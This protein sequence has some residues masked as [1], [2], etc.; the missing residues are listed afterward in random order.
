MSRNDYNIN[1]NDLNFVDPDFEENNHFL[2][3][4]SSNQGDFLSELCNY[5]EFDQD[6]GMHVK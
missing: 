2:R 4:L 1:R 6:I 5:N 3:G